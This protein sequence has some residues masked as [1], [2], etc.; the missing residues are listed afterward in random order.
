MFETQI[1]LS[2]NAM[3]ESTLH[4]LLNIARPARG[5]RGREAGWLARKVQ[6]AEGLARVEGGRVRGQSERG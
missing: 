3:C 6:H 2:L 4:Q 1:K 5:A